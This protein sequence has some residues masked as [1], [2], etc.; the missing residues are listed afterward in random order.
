V[1]F[2]L[3]VIA[4]FVINR[5]DVYPLQEPVCC[6]GILGS[7]EPGNK[8][9]NETNN[10]DGPE[11]DDTAPRPNGTFIKSQRGHDGSCHSNN[12]NKNL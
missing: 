10:T 3:S 9:Q 1:G 12:Q 5:W 4:A 7:L 11:T 6:I 8:C 2:L